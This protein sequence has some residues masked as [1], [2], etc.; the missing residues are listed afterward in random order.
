MKFKATCGFLAVFATLAAYLFL[1]D[2]PRQQARQHQLER[3]GLVLPELEPGAVTAVTL[4]SAKGTVR[5]ER[6]EG[7]VW[8]VTAP[9]PDRGNTNRVRSL[10][11]DIGTLRAERAVAGADANLE[12]YGLV[13]PE[14]LVALE[15]PALSLAVGGV[16]PAGDA[17]YLRAGNGPV[18][19]V[20][21]QQVTSLLLDPDALRRRKPLLVGAWPVRGVEVIRGQESRSYDQIGGVWR[22][23]GEA[24]ETAEGAALQ[25]L[26]TVLETT[27][28]D[29]VI[30]APDAA[31][32][33]LEPMAIKLAVALDGGS[34]QEIAL[35]Q[36]G[37]Q[38]YA[39]AGDGTGPVYALP[40]AFGETLEALLSAPETTAPGR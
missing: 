12:P 4:H 19:V 18:L 6:G 30:D 37:S 5:V 21:S 7:D 22:R 28:A 15:G 17:R 16:T 25:A 23:G 1:V 34:R 36:L 27:A 8:N 31:A 9:V 3:R 26:V 40:I 14:L 11:A 24:L 39:R 35:G 32:Y 13:D 2:E 33:G 29:Q 20:K 38:R 10:L